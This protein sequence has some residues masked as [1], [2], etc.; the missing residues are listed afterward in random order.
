M[1]INL[2]YKQKCGAFSGCVTLK[3]EW[4]PCSVSPAEYPV[5]P[6][7]VATAALF[8]LLQLPLGQCI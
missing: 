4:I 3:S 8:P 1:Y 7:R 2:S 5:L 6:G